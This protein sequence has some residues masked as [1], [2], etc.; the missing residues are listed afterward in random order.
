MA[1]PMHLVHRSRES[2]TKITLHNAYLIGIALKGLDGL[3]EIAGGTALLLVSRATML[4]VAAFV[5]GSGSSGTPHGAI[6]AYVLHATVTLSASTQHF[7]SLYLIVHGAIKVGLVVGLIRGWRAAY[8]VSLLLL[9]A[10]IG[11]QCYRLFQYR[12]P[13]LA[14]FTA[15]DIVIVLLIWHEWRSVRGKLA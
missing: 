12:S 8:P 3:I 2:A 9:T 1:A 15:I 10:F 13:A 14:V 4:Q 6:A 11:Y 7:A 5:S